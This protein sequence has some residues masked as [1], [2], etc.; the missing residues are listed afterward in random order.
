MV[1]GG[2]EGCVRDLQTVPSAAISRQTKSTAADDAKTG[3]HSTESGAWKR[4][5]EGRR[6]E[7]MEGKGGP[8]GA[9]SVFSV[10]EPT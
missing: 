10:I 2:G 9:E 1:S 4:M 6:R 3:E 8:V 5:D 7:G